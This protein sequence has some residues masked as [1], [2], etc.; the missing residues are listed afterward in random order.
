MPSEQIQR[1]FS[2]YRD[3]QTAVKEEGV[4]EVLDDLK[5]YFPELYEEISNEFRRR[6]KVKELGVLLAGPM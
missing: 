4:R 5:D 3:L 1:L 2:I 6:Q